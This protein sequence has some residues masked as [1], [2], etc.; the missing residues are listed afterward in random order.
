MLQ[1]S[2]T[3]ITK[4]FCT[5]VKHSEHQDPVFQNLTKL[6][7]KL[8]IKFQRSKFWNIANILIYFAGKKKWAVLAKATNIFCSKNINVFENILATTVNKFV[9]NQHVKLTMLWTTGP[10]CLMGIAYTLK[11]FLHFYKVDNDD[12]PFSAACIRVQKVDEFFNAS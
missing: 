3:K 12:C 2:N 7:A 6:L 9:T 1:L 10:S 5:S 4:T 11:I 8:T